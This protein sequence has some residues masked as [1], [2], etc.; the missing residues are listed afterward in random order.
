MQLLLV[1]AVL[2]AAL[3]RLTVLLRQLLE[4]QFLYHQ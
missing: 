1:V 3:L 2:E 4:L